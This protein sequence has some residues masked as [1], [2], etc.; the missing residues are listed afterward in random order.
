[1]GRVEVDFNERVISPPG[2]GM[3]K[4]AIGTGRFVRTDK[5][6]TSGTEKGSSCRI[7]C[8]S[9]LPQKTGV[10]VQGVG[11]REAYPVDSYQLT[12]KN[13]SYVGYIC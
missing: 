12:E 3:G 13:T 7:S 6:V 5:P 11:C 1:M 10:K 8:H 4:A 9:S 2:I